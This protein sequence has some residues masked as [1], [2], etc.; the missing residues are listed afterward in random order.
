MSDERSILVVD[1][2]DV[3]TWAISKGLSRPGELYVE[4][5]KSAEEAVEILRKLTFDLVIT[6]VRMRGMS[7]LE[8][9][10]HIKER[11]P[12]TGVMVITAYGS[13]E[14]RQDA[15]ERGALAYY[16]KTIDLNDLR[17]AVREVLTKVNTSSD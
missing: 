16:E 11:Y 3:I 12:R 15:L 1:D 6:D 10:S 5:T 13:D 4:T 14:I 8:L 2:E 17:T 7:G 9:C